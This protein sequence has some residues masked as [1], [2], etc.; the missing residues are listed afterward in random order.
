MVPLLAWVAVNQNELLSNSD[1]RK[2]GIRF[3]VDFNNHETIDLSIA[4]NLTECTIVKQSENGKLQLTHPQEPQQTP[5]FSH[6]FWKLYAGE[7]LLAEW[8]T[9]T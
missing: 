7:N 4:L 2:T 1:L 6:P 3:E 9:P 5:E 8:A